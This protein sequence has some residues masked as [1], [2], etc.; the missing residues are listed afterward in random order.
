MTFVTDGDL[1]IR[2]T[3]S[4]RSLRSATDETADTNESVRDDRETTDC[5]LRMLGVGKSYS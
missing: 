3:V 5:C 1:L 4:S 2:C